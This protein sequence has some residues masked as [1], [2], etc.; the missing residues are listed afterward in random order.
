MEKLEFILPEALAQLQ[1]YFVAYPYLDN[2][3]EEDLVCC[4]PLSDDSIDCSVVKRQFLNAWATEILLNPAAFHHLPAQK[5]QN[6]VEIFF[7]HA[8]HLKQHALSTTS[9]HLNPKQ[10]EMIALHWMAA[11]HTLSPELTL[12]LL[13]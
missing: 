6:T 11:A 10:K 13:Q 9:P 4:F 7:L 1:D 12:A 3:H 5:R 2:D 8:T